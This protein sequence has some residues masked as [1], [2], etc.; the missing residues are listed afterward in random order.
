MPD[1]NYDGSV[2]EYRV[3]KRKDTQ[4]A[5]YIEMTPPAWS[6]GGVPQDAINEK[7]RE[8]EKETDAAPSQA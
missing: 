5:A 6:S 8:N 7:S 2:A 3:I 4:G 1:K